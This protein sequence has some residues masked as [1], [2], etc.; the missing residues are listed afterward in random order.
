LFEQDGK[1]VI[2]LEN[3]RSGLFL[4]MPSDVELFRKAAE[5]ERR[6]ALSQDE[7]TGS[8]PR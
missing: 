2:H 1:T 7:S 4:H 3:R 6:V 8:S 5:W